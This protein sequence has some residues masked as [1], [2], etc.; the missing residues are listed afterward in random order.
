MSSEWNSP[1]KRKTVILKEYHLINAKSII[2]CEYNHLANPNVKT[3]SGKNFQCMLKL[4][5]EGFGENSIH[6]MLTVS[7]LQ[8]HVDFKEDVVLKLRNQVVTFLAKRSVS[9]T[10]GG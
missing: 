4:L 1:K 8:S 5:C 6:L 3:D 2:E 9:I 7:P 10:Y